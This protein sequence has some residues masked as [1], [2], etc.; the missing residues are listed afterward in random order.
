MPL[1]GEAQAGGRAAQGNFVGA[2][3]VSAHRSA[4]AL[5]RAMR[6]PPTSWGEACRAVPLIAPCDRYSN[7]PFLQPS[8]IIDLLLVSSPCNRSKVLSWGLIKIINLKALSL[9][10]L[11]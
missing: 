6:C 5:R 2:D 10:E 3:L 9:S 1:P 7:F 4:P 8:I 11:K